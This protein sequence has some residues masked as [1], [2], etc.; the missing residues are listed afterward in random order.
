MILQLVTPIQEHDVSAATITASALY[1]LST[2]GGDKADQYRKWGDTILKNLTKDYRAKLNSNGG[3]LLLHSTGAKSLN[4]EID[5]PL[6][7]SDY[8]FME[9]LIRKQKLDSGKG[10]FK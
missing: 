6:L 7:Y 2:Y 10:L 5:V 4:S 8:F 1:E 3:F 9:A